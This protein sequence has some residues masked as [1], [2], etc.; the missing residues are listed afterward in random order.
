MLSWK[1]VIMFPFVSWYWMKSF[2]IEWWPQLLLLY[3]S[4]KLCLEV[5]VIMAYQVLR[6]HVQINVHKDRNMFMLIKIYFTIVLEDYCKHEH[7][8]IFLL[9]Y[10]D[11]STWNSSKAMFLY[12]QEEK[13]TR[14]S[15]LLLFVSAYCLCGHYNIWKSYHG[16]PTAVCY[17]GVRLSLIAP[18]ITDLSLHTFFLTFIIILGRI[19]AGWFSGVSIP[20][21]PNLLCSTFLIEWW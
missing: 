7:I 3:L 16:T 1:A 6:L 20:A 4:W 8:C 21:L 10:L 11:V 5:S 13:Y 17:G 2:L 19:V 18:G 15:P 14:E 12:E 9:I